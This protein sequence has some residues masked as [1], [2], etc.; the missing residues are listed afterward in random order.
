MTT[1]SLKLPEDLKKRTA[2]VAQELGATPHAFMVSAIRTAAAAEEK[3]A[4]FIADAKKARKKMLKTGVG[5]DVDEV[6]AYLRH[7]IANPD[8][9]PAIE[10]PKAKSWRT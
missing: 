2:A 1:T 6:H 4:E 9:K 8:L 5:F 7:R 10:Q 3:R